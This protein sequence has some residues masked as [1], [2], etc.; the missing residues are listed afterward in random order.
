MRRAV[1]KNIK[2][3]ASGGIHNFRTAKKMLEA[4]ADVIGT[5]SGLDIIGKNK[6]KKKDISGSHE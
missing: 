3:K 4:G 6:I 5:S 2:V 1:S